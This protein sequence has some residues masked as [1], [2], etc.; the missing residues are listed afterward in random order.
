MRTTQLFL[1]CLFLT[2]AL[3]L[4]NVPAQNYSQWSLLEG[5]TARIGKGVITDIAYSPD[6][7][8]LAVA[9][10]I[11]IWIYDARTGAELDLLTRQSSIY[12]VAYSPDGR[13][14]A[15]ADSRNV[16]LWD[17]VTGKYKTTL[18]TATKDMFF[19]I[20]SITY[21]PDGTTLATAGGAAAYLW[22]ADT[23]EHKT[24]L[25]EHVHGVN[26]LMYSPD[27]KTIATTIGNYTV[28]LWDADTKKRKVTLKGHT[29][30]V[31]SV[32]Y[33]PDG[34]TIATA[35]RG[36]VR[37]WDAKTGRHTVTLK[38]H[39]LSPDLIAYSPDGKTIATAIGSP[40]YR[41]HDEIIYFWDANTGV[42]KKD[43]KNS[44]KEVFGFVKSVTYSP[45][46]KTIA[47]A[48]G[49]KVLFSDAE[50]GKR[51]ETILKGD[52]SSISSVTYSPDG[53]VIA[54]AGEREVRLWDFDIG[55]Y[56]NI[57][58]GHTKSIASVAYSPDGT[59]LASAS[60]NEVYFWDSDTGKNI[61]TLKGHTK[62]IT[63][64]AYSPDGKTFITAS[65]TGEGEV[66]LW[67]VETEEHKRTL[68]GY[69]C[70]V[71]SP[72]GNTITTAS[73]IGEVHF[74][75]ADM[76]RHKIILKQHSRNT[77]PVY[78]PDG[79]T[80]ATASYNGTTLLWDTRVLASQISQQSPMSTR[81]V[82]TEN[83]FQDLIDNFQPQQP[84]IS[85]AEVATPQTPQQIAKSAL[86]STVLI[87]MGDVNGQLLSTGSGFFVDRG[88]I[89]TNLHVVEGVF[90]GYVKR[91]GTD[92]T[93]RI[94]GIVAMDTRQDLALIKVSDVDAPALS[95]GGSDKVQVGE[96]VY[97][98]GNPIGFLEGTFSNGIVSGVR[99]FRVGSQRIQITAPI[100]E[101]SS[102]GPVLN[103][104]GEV[105]GVA[106][107]TITAGQNLNFAIPSNYLSEL[108]HK[109]KG[110]K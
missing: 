59:T 13:T 14:L 15:A 53:K 40:H 64:V 51:H 11:G 57:L 48:I 36:E 102:G 50:T 7:R 63:F 17:V 99:E 43:C 27:G 82:A 38:E 52:T 49:N 81:E 28:C 18:I 60:G 80:L 83:P 92:K 76:R 86:A 88:I 12:S 3:F 100:S 19:T 103:S 70:L 98:A 73:T 29:D 65:N 109:A 41:Q 84:S 39:M 9:S 30:T 107:S 66:Q 42:H 6:S 5:V 46:G 56:K 101:G 69:S 68:K 16:F 85:V 1:S 106:V 20:N 67:D 79:K 55:K 90:S 8:Q 37:F 61:N 24:T 2:F 104:N 75:N 87:V 105:I 25:I 10:L 31:Y 22:N 58:R 34:K 26:S 62:S 78:S 32:A 33:S 23:G 94:E 47:A 93:Y 21:S 72:D 71:Y 95:L 35:S 96:S 54:V 4:P 108:L 97:V 74:W 45:D 89:A 44:K 77:T 110:R 91:V